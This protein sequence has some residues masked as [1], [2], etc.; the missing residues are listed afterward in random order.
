MFKISHILRVINIHIQLALQLGIAFDIKSA[1]RNEEFLASVGRTSISE[2]DLQMHA[3]VIDHA[4]ERASML[5]RMY[6]ELRSCYAEQ[7]GILSK[8]K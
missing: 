2:I 8:I 3:D 4:K 6:N 7:D 5:L 1:E